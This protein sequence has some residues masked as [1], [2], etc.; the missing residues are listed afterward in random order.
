M[1][2]RL[3]ASTPISAFGAL[4][5]AANVAQAALITY[6]TRQI[7][8]GVNSSDYRASWAAQ[9][10]AITSTSVANLN[11]T[12]PGNN[13][14]VHVRIEFIVNPVANLSFQIAPDAGY[15]GALY[16][17]GSRIEHEVTDLW[18]GYNFAASS[19][20]LQ[21]GNGNYPVSS[22]VLEGFWAE[23]CC[24]GQQGGRFSVNGGAWQDLSVANLDALN[25]PA[26]V[27]EPGTLALFGLGLMGT[28]YAYRRRKVG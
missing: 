21:S 2:S 27:P 17:N 20:L 14:F 13:S 25:N 12:V 6:E 28:A 26:A 22:Y 3:F 23:N 24:N 19:E 16:L 7:T 11:G 1:K 8:S 5:L 4:V 18:W 9:S 15:G 10:S